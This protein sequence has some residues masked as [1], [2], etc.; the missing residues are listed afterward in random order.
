MAVVQINPLRVRYLPILTSLIFLHLYR[1]ARMHECKKKLK[2]GCPRRLFV[3][4][5]K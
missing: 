4:A 2:L 5:C 1:K 3:F